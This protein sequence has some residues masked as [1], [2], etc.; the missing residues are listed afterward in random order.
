MFYYSRAYP[1]IICI[2]LFLFLLQLRYLVLQEYSDVQKFQN[3]PFYLVRAPPTDPHPTGFSMINF[4]SQIGLWFDLSY[5]ES[6]GMILSIKI[7]LQKNKF[8]FRHFPKIRIPR[9][10]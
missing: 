5:E 7:K 4:S 1:L 3:C 9:K 8:N 2:L 6:K 10:F